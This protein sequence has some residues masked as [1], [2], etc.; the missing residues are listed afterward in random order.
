MK[1]L[2]QMLLVLCLVVFSTQVAFANSDKVT[3][4]EGADITGI[5]RLALAK[6][7][8]MQTDKL[9]PTMD[10]LIQ[11]ESEASKV[12][13]MYVIP[14]DTVA[15][16]VKTDTKVDI[17]ALDRHQG[18][19]ANPNCSTIITLMGIAP[20]HKQVPLRH[21]TAV[22]FQSVSGTG[23]AAIEELEQQARAYATGAGMAVNAYPHQIAFN[24]L[25]Q[26]GGVKKEMPG[27][28]SEEAK[29]T[30][31]SRK[32]LGSP[33]LRIASTCVRVPVFYAHS[34]A[35]HAEFSAPMPPEQARE[36]LARADGVKVIDD[37]A[38]A[39]YPM[40]LFIGGGDDV[41][42]GRIRVDPS[43]ENGLA[44][45]CCGDNIRKGAAQNA[46]QIAEAMIRRSLI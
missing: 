10:Q 23:R 33:E 38:A 16:S 18:F 44:L 32:I 26:I 36:I 12:A 11:I 35:I 40:P 6:P 3:L 1:K 29:L 21:M 30:F 14:Y 28:T 22:T 43:V 9:A 2:M 45:W 13:R 19:I 20:L 34:I 24:V 5:H 27:F 8:Y 17:K 41:G 25:P 31:E 15:A 37:L 46:V 7:L 42:V 39:Q 4:V